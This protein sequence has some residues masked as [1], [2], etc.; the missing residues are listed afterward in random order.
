MCQG[1][2]NRAQEPTLLLLIFDFSVAVAGT[3]LSLSWFL[4]CT[5]LGTPVLHQLYVC[6]F[7]LQGAGAS[8]AEDME[9][10]AALPAYVQAHP[11]TSAEIRRLCQDLQVLGRGE[12]KALLKW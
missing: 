5:L 2:H 7:V 6:R 8:P 12:F 1:T 10:G 11:A 4:C 9:W 3:L